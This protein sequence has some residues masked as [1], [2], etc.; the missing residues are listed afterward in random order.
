MAG[1]T[2][3]ATRSICRQFGCGAVLTEVTNAA[4]LVHNSKATWHLFQSSSGERPLGAHIYGADPDVLAKAAEL[5]NK[6]GCFDFIDLN[7]GCPVRKIMLKGAGAALV[8]DPAKITKLVRAMT[9]VSALPV[10]VKTRIGATAEKE[11]A[12]ELAAAVKAGGGSAVFLH[13][14]YTSARHS[15]RAHWDVLSRVTEAKILPVIGNGGIYNAHDAFRMIRETGVSGV[16]IGR[17]AVGNPW[18]FEHILSI[19]KTGTCQ[20]HSLKEHRKV[21]MS[22][23]G[24]LLELKK[25]EPRYKKKNQLTIEYSTILHF[26]AHLYRYLSGFNSWAELRRRL[27]S[28]K[29]IDELVSLVE[30]VF[31]NQQSDTAPFTGGLVDVG[32]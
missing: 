16:M 10:T 28:L 2:D 18:I 19:E 12:L 22:H 21:I 7:C 25:I 24:K 30:Q 14:R 9:N 32:K 31:S 6:T 1:Y 20:P 15:G 8:T 5:I 11:N 27:N 26:R 23:L 3:S 17:A 4:G 29:T 13:A